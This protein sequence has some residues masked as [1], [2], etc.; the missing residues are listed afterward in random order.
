[1]GWGLV[2]SSPEAR[3]WLGEMQSSLDTLPAKYRAS[4]CLIDELSSPTSELT[5]A[6]LSQ[7]LCAAFQ[8]I[9]VNFLRSSG[10]SFTSVSGHSSSEIAA[11]YA[12]GILYATDAVR[13]AHLRGL[14]ASLDA[15]KSGQPGA[16]LAAGLPAEYTAVLRKSAVLILY[17]PAAQ[18]D[19][20]ILVPTHMK[21]ATINPAFACG[22]V[23]TGTLPSDAAITKLDADVIC[24]D[25]P[26]ARDITAYMEPVGSSTE[27]LAVAWIAL[28]CIKRVEAQLAED[29]QRNLDWHRSRLTSWIDR[30]LSLTRTGGHPI[31]SASWLD[32]SQEDF[33]TLL[34]KG[35]VSVMSEAANVVGTNLHLF[36]RGEAS[37]LEELRK[38]DILTRF[39][40][41][42]MEMNMMNERLGDILGQFVFRYPRMT[43]LEDI[44]RSHHSYTFTDICGVLRRG[45]VYISAHEDRFI[46]FTIEY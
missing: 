14:V 29:D 11:V 25:G 3:R 35:S 28:L 40:R 39:Y 7:T 44:G 33:D 8:I 20:T 24:G 27:V 19:C 38:N 6:S 4:F 43:I 2:E 1:M 42:D 12:S 41:H 22:A 10:V 34:S 31:L 15:A 30:T 21:F 32:T 17:L 23:G 5:S 26:L 9:P 16:M 45:R 46:F 37:I 36:F 18:H 13:I